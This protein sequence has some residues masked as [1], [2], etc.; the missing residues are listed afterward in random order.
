MAAV[1]CC[2]PFEVDA[3]EEE[4]WGSVE[5]ELVVVVVVDWRLL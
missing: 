5:V 2:P 4:Y 1:Y 3:S